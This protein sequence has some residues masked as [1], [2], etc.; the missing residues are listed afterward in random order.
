MTRASRVAHALRC[1]PGLLGRV[2]ALL[3]VPCEGY[4]GKCE[5]AGTV[6][7]A[8]Q[9]RYPEPDD[10]EPGDLD[11]NRDYFFCSQCS[12]GYTEQMNDQWAEYHAGLL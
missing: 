6:I 9:T 10:Q 3:G 1:R 5:K 11:R 7:T 2:L 8:S 4:Q 12:D